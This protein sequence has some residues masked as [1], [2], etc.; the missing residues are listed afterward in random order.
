LTSKAAQKQAQRGHAQK[1][2]DE[3]SVTDAGSLAA[4]NFFCAFH[5]SK[6]EIVSLYWPIGSELDTLPLLKKLHEAGVICALP[7]I[8]KKDH[9]LSFRRWRPETILQPGPFKV[10]I[11]PETDEM[12][13]P[14]VVVTPL[15]AFDAAGYR[16]GYGGGFYDRTLE[17]LRRNS[18]CKA[19]GYG[20]V[21]Q[22]VETIVT[23]QYDQQLD[24]M[25]TEID[26]RTFK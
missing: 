10:P 15:L 19:I 11:P 6:H 14:S 23:D 17:K 20:Y 8:K 25:V 1:I 18:G 4:L 2:R 7:V 22:E 13:L 9:P 24:A 12:V 26:V 3:L 16:L 21:G 5:L